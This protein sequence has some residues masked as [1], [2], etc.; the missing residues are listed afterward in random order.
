[1]RRLRRIKIT[2]GKQ[3][4]TLLSDLEFTIAP[5]LVAATARMASGITVKDVVGER[6]DLTRPTGYLSATDLSVLRTMIRGGDA[7]T[8]RY[9][10]L[11]GDASGRFYVDMPEFKSFRYGAD[12]VT[13]WY[14]VTLRATGAEVTAV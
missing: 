6:V 7:V 9:P 10:D 13:I 2:D 5:E 3:T 1:M 12:G 11:D 8:I 4:V 14:G